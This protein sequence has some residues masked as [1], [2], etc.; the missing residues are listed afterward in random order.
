MKGINLE[1]DLILLNQRNADGGIPVERNA[2]RGI[3]GLAG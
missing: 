3:V 2:L 1:G